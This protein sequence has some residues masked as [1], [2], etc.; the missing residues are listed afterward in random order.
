MA[1]GTRGSS[2]RQVSLLAGL[3]KNRNRRVEQIS[4]QQSTIPGRYN[5]PSGLTSV[6]FF[7]DYVESQADGVLVPEILPSARIRSYGHSD[8]TELESV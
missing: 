3:N 2:L 6:G 8:L 5:P 7:I 1:E 4:G